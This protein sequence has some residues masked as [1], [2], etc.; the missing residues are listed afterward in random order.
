MEKRKHEC[1][2]KNQLADAVSK[3]TNINY[4]TCLGLI[5]ET[6]DT[7]M[8]I[9]SNKKSVRIVGFGVFDYVEKKSRQ[10]I[11]PDTREKIIIPELVSP[12]F[13]AG[14]EFKKAVKNEDY[15]ADYHA[16]VVLAKES[17]ESNNQANI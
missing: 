14:S 9:V 8:E 2:N 10:G 3:K 11:N 16:N 4:E 7:I 5:E 1:L 6:F 15:I 17:N 13:R 12:T